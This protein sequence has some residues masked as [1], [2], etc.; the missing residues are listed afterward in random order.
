MT[1]ERCFYISRLLPKTESSIYQ[2]KEQR[3]V[4]GQDARQISLTHLSKKSFFT[5]LLQVHIY[6]LYMQYPKLPIHLIQKQLP[7]C[8]NTYVQC[9]Q[10]NIYHIYSREVFVIIKFINYVQCIALDRNICYQFEILVGNICKQVEIYSQFQ[11]KKCIF[12]H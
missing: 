2:L 4:C 7:A 11:V 9:T 6:S 12:Y 8:L 3:T 1:K 5:L 10:S